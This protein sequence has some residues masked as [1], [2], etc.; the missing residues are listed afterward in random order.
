MAWR[1]TQK[2]RELL[3]FS[4]YKKLIHESIKSDVILTD[5][6][7]LRGSVT[8]VTLRCQGTLSSHII[9]K[10]SKCGRSSQIDDLAC[11][12]PCREFHP[13]LRIWRLD[14]D[15]TV[16]SGIPQRQQAV[17]LVSPCATFP[18]LNFSR[19]V[20]SVAVAVAGLAMMGQTYASGG[21]GGHG[22]GHGGHGGGHGG[23]GGGHGR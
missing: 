12:K 10:S 9:S 17:E 16:A 23:H 19:L 1:L 20:C 18:L 7:L 4:Q 3:V 13:P 11:V 14:C 15:G 22:G 8:L 2:A 5:N 21:H 6:L